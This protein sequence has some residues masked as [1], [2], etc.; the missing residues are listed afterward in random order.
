MRATH[1]HARSFT[2]TC[3]RNSDI[4]TAPAAPCAAHEQRPSSPRLLAGRLLLLLIAV[5]LQV[6]VCAACRRGDVAHSE[7]IPRRDAAVRRVAAGVLVV[8]ELH[9]AVLRAAAHAL[10]Y[11]RAVEGGG[12]R[13]DGEHLV[14]ALHAFKA[15][16]EAHDAPR[17][18]LEGLLVVLVLEDVAVMVGVVPHHGGEDPLL[19]VLL[20]RDLV[21][22]PQLLR[23]AAVAGPAARGSR[24]LA[25]LHVDLVAPWLQAS[26]EHLYYIRLADARVPHVL[27][28]HRRQLRVR[29]VL[30]VLDVVGSHV[31]LQR[32]H[33]QQP[34]VDHDP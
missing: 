5:I 24:A 18:E 21:A 33:T 34:H 17:T 19:R 6:V 3:T 25:R 14:A 15:L 22:A 2:D 23:L 32:R 11:E 12:V 26:Q 4:S 10:R 28:T 27:R 31:A 20:R 7:H 16:V 1:P 9:V 8:H 13:E 30:R 29:D